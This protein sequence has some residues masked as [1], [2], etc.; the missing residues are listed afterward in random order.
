NRYAE[1]L[2]RDNGPGIPADQADRIFEPYVT[3]KS[4]GTGLGL[5]IVKKIVEEHGGQ[6]R[7]EAAETGGAAFL[8]RLPTAAPGSHH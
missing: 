1:L 2:I 8:I 5:A 7:L 4:K 3:T 6:I